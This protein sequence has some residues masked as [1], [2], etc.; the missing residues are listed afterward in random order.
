MTILS[1]LLAWGIIS[2]D[3]T[4]WGHTIAKGLPVPNLT[5][6]GARSIVSVIA[7]GMISVISLVFSLTFVALTLMSQQLGPRILLFFMSDQ[8]TKVVLGIFVS[9]FVYALFTLV[10]IGTGAE[11]KFVP[12]L[13]IYVTCFYALMALAAVVMFVQ[14][15]ANAMQADAVVARLAARLAEVIQ[16]ITSAE[17]NESETH[18][19]KIENGE[20]EKILEE[21]TKNG[22][23][24]SVSKSGYV[25]IVNIET[26]LEASLKYGMQVR[27]DCR[28]GD[29]LVEGEQIAAITPARGT[30]READDVIRKAF[31]I[32]SR[33]TPDDT[34]DFETNALVEVALRALSPGVNDPYTAIACIDHLSD[35]LVR[36]AAAVRRTQVFCDED[37]NARVY[38]YPQD[39][40]YPMNTVFHPLVYASRGNVQVILKLIDALKRIATVSDVRAECESV[41][42]HIEILEEEIKTNVGNSFHK[43]DALA[44]LAIVKKILASES[45]R[46]G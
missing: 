34:A 41:L 18:I 39:F 3:G 31:V 27:L 38:S 2:I 28:P 4:E 7:G 23:S 33:R 37:G 17:Q 16:R 22:R 26:M 13:A 11:E 45:K 1:F 30:N 21:T 24:V 46:V 5:V 20:F 25:Q 12:A 44:E 14:H 9:A 6:A 8:F 40:E 10:A 35:A 36:L 43:K 19:R 29:Y 42:R 15:I 32:G